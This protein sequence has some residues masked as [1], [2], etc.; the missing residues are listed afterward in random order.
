MA[1][2]EESH[3]WGSALKP[4]TSWSDLDELGNVL[5]GIFN[6]MQPAI[7]FLLLPFVCPAFFMVME[8]L[9]VLFL[10]VQRYRGLIS[11]NFSYESAGASRKILAKYW[12][13][14][15]QIWHG[16]EVHGMEN[17]PDT[18]PALIIFYH[19]RAPIDYLY[20][21]AHLTLQKE[22]RCHTVA[23]FAVF[24]I[25]GLGPLLSA[26][27]A[28]PGP[29][30]TCVQILE[31]GH[32]LGIS[33]GGVREAVLSDSNYTLVWCT[34]TGFAQVALTVGVPI[35]PMFTKNLQE[36]CYLVSIFGNKKKRNSCW[37]GGDS[38]HCIDAPVPIPP[39][40]PKA[41][42]AP[43]STK[44]TT[45]C[46]VTMVHN[47]HNKT[48]GGGLLFHCWADVLPDVFWLHAAYLEI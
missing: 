33:P 40:H 20:F 21:L 46:A 10:H 11:K 4:W 8:Y 7:P 19:G 35:I 12:Y 6:F 34:R 2:S 30:S 44:S 25:P 41:P 36:S 17:I 31:S 14:W 28:I 39:K 9:S 16:Y 29:Q 22:R 27:G 43:Q 18:G 24:K 26:F 1:S 3:E 48:T 13:L 5:V 23:D 15:S 47:K 42:K 32:L 45:R 38:T 37:E